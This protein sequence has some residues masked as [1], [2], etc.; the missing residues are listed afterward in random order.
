MAKD[1]GFWPY[2]TPSLPLSEA[3][4]TVDGIELYYRTGGSG[5][6]LVL[7]H[8]FTLTG[9]E[10]DPFLGELGKHNT[11]ILPDLPGMGRSSRPTGDFT[12]RETARLTFGLLDALGVGRVRG[13]GHSSGGIML[14]H[15]ALQQPDRM[16]AIVLVA[17]AHRLPQDVRQER[18]AG[19]RRW[20][21]L[22]PE[23]LEDLR[24]RSADSLDNEAI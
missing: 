10:W 3:T 13:M 20:D 15:M 1:A 8:G 23:R 7:L 21:N 4:E 14:L 2:V 11:V 9:E 18:R 22:S 6:P 24:R 19:V 12:H 16:E 17:G 5:P